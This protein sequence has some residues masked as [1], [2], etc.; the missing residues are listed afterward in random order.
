M[1]T[2]TRRPPNGVLP[3]LKVCHIISSFSP[4]I[5]GAEKATQSLA[6]TLLRRGHDVVVLTRRYSRADPRVE[7][8]DGVPVFRL[9]WPGRGKVNALTFGIDALAVLVWRLGSWRIVHVQNI[10]TPMLVGMLARLLLRRRLV[11]TIHGHTQIMGRNRSRLG[12]LRTRAMARTVDRYTSINPENTAV[13][14]RLGVPRDRIHEIPNGVDTQNFRP[15]D[16]SA[17]EGARTELGLTPDEFV[18]VYIGRLVAWKRVDL[19]I[20]AWGRA[21]LGG[22][23][24]LLI[25]GGGQEA[26]A[27]QAM[28]EA[29]GPSVR[30]EGSSD[31]PLT[32]LHAAD[33]FVNVSG[34][35][36][37]QGEGL[38]V[39]LLEAMASGVPPLVTQG[40]G[41]D[42]LIEH[43]KTGLSIS[44][45]DADALRASLEL[46][47][48][49]ADLRLRLGQAAHERVKQRYSIEAV[50][51]QVED[52]YRSI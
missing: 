14:R 25:V 35:D 21:D 31:R 37:T 41:N 34:N 28:A 2:N 33:V 39:A 47:S 24:R 52:V 46:V 9:G 27:L 30:M 4:V 15:A 13:L 10:D 7:R 38:S 18:A 6:S 20:E 32:Y 12:R 49:D 43:G 22:R 45:E 19:L 40:P 11:A 44:V 23:G 50:A 29:V 5:G 8:I 36:G 17:R 42:V 1:P 51:A 48:R 3:R 26:R 16:K